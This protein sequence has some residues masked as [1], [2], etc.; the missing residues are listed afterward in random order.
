MHFLRQASHCFQLTK[1][2]KQMVN[3]VRVSGG[4][5]IIHFADKKNVW[6]KDLQQQK[7]VVELLQ[8]YVKGNGGR[9]KG[10]CL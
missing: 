4:K 9:P 6:L 2:N 7:D 1:C 8:E 5:V 10:E 3:Q